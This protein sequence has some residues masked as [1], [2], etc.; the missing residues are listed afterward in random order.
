M[1][2]TLIQPSSSP[3]A[4]VD[5]VKLTIRFTAALHI[6]QVTLLNQV[7]HVILQL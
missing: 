7:K 3:E 6:W 1:K 5:S 2:F 4:M